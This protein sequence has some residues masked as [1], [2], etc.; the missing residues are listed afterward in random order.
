VPHQLRQ[1]ALLAERFIHQAHGSV[2]WA[3]Q[4]RPQGWTQGL[5]RVE[6]G[7][8]ALV[9]AGVTVLA[10]EV[11]E[12]SD[13]G[14]AVRMRVHQC[15]RRQKRYF[16]VMSKSHFDRLQGGA[17][18]SSAMTAITHDEAR[19]S[20]SRTSSGLAF[21]LLSATSFGLSGPLAKGLLDAGWSPGA[22]VT[23]RIL[24]A[25]AV[26]SPPAA[27]ALRGRWRLVRENLVVLTV[28]GLVAVAGCQLAFFNAVDHMQVG[29]ALLIEYTAP[30]AVL[31]WHWVR[32]G[33]APTRVTVLGAC[34]AGVGLVMVLDLVSGAE[35]SLVGV[36][37][38]L[39]AMVGVATFFVISADDDNGLPAVVLA[40]GGLI[41]GGAALL[42]AGLAGLVPLNTATAAVS[43]A[44]T[45]V[46]WWVPV[47]LLGVVT[48]AIAYATGIEAGR[49]L[50]SRVASFVGLL[51]VL[52][53]LVFAWLLLGELPR[54]VQLLG[55]ILILAG[56]V[57]V[58]LGDKSPLNGR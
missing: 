26:L 34:L 47:L 7:D 9:G 55:G 31:G 12:V 25:A 21:A 48:A 22:A 32:H 35:L 30:V 15:G 46:G 43:L 27:F 44:G 16:S 3:S 14:Q 33:T 1:G 54:L 20:L 18:V 10:E 23:A 58:R 8:G 4:E 50:G 37:W 51:E 42:L 49:R 56:V 28:Y 40:D 17:L 38:A 41:I 11:V 53:A 2:A 5:D 57:V 39:A 6:F 24:I 29:V 36:V 13:G 52:A 45:P 19:S